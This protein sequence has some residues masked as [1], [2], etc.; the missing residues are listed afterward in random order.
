MAWGVGDRD[1]GR[2]FIKV[3]SGVVRNITTWVN[4]GAEKL[5]AGDSDRIRAYCMR[6]GANLN[7]V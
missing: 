4:V 5:R 1:K 2:I 6:R 7:G 3:L